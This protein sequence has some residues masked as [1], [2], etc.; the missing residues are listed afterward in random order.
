MLSS[1]YIIIILLLSLMKRPRWRA[2][3][4]HFAPWPSSSGFPKHA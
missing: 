3:I 1:D 2:S 4:M